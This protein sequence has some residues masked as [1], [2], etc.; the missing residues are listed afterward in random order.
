MEVKTAVSVP[1]ERDG[2]HV[3]VLKFDPSDVVFMERVYDLMDHL[4]QKR[5]QY[6]AQAEALEAEGEKNEYGIPKNARAYLK[7]LREI[8]A[9]AHGEIDK[10]FGAETSAMVFG[11][12]LSLDAVADFFT[13]LTPYLDE[14][15]EEKMENYLN[16]GQRRA[17]KK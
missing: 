8:C 2:A 15:R 1:I 3:G 16:R 6:A 10:V 7:L 17:L 11:E 12:A 5:A 4:E 9:Y 13:Q 14:V